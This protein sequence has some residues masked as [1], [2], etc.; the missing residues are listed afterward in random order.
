MPNATGT[1]LVGEAFDLKMSIN[2]VDS[3]GDGT[4]DD[5]QLGLWF[6][7]VLYKNK[8]LELQD[9]APTLGSMMSIY[10]PYEGRYVQVV[11][12]EVDNNADLSIFGFDRN[13]EDYLDRTGKPR[14]VRTEL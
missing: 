8:F 11:S 7:D 6:N 3:D 14:T 13:Y 4:A 5:V 12:T 2:Y 1:T 10:S 9:V